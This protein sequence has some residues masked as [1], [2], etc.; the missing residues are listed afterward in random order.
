MCNSPMGIPVEVRHFK[1]GSGVVG[2]DSCLAQIVQALNDGGVKTNQSCCGHYK[3]PGEIHLNDGRELIVCRWITP[4]RFN[5]RHR[6]INFLMRPY[7]RK[8]ADHDS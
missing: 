5:L 2:I 6:A 7:W 1:D 4:T 3:G 8:E